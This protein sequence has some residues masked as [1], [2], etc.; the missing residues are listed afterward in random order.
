MERILPAAFESTRALHVA[1][2]VDL[3]DMPLCMS[4]KSRYSKPKFFSDRCGAARV[5]P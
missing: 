3:S 5:V 1:R 2:R 4:M